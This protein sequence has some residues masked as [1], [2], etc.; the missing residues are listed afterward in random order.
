MGNRARLGGLPFRLS[1]YFQGG[2]RH[3]AA[4]ARRNTQEYGTGWAA[5]RAREL[6]WRAAHEAWRASVDSTIGEGRNEAWV[7][8]SPAFDEK[9]GGHEFVIRF[10]AE[11]PPEQPLIRLLPPAG[12]GSALTGIGAPP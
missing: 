2:A 6:A 11:L 1:R 12:R 8:V 5:F 7:F 4:R 10:G 9:S 3:G